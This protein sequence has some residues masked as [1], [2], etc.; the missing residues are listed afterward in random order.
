M[1]PKMGTIDVRIYLL[2]I[3]F[4]IFLEQIYPGEA[5][6]VCFKKF[7]QGKGDCKR[8]LRKRVYASAS[9]CCAG[10]GNG[11]AWKEKKIRKNSYR[12]SSCESRNSLTTPSFQ[13]STLAPWGEWS[14]CTVTCGAGWRSKYRQC[15]TC[16][17][18]DYRNKLFQPCMINSY[19]PVDGNWGPWYPWQPCSKSCGTGIR[20]RT[21]SCIYPPPAHGG[22]D[23]AGKSDDKDTC[24]TKPCPVDG[25]WTLWTPWSSCTESCG[26][27]TMKRTRTCSNPQ[28][29]YRGK[30]C[31]GTGY[32]IKKCENIRCPQDGGWSLWSSWSP[33]PV[34]CGLGFRIRSRMCNSPKPM[35][36]GSSC[37]GPYTEKLDCRGGRPCPVPIHG[38]WSNWSEFGSCKAPRCTAIRGFKYRYRTCTNPKPHHYGQPCHGRS[39][40]RRECY[41]NFECPV[42]G[43]WCQWSSWGPCS[44]RNCRRSDAVEKRTRECSCPKP[45]FKGAPC[46]KEESWETRNCSSNPSCNPIAKKTHT[47]TLSNIEVSL[48]T[49]QTSTVE[50]STIC[51]NCTTVAIPEVTSS[52]KIFNSTVYR[53]L[54]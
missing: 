44:R 42:D 40:D 49:T 12:C 9:D 54:P 20:T 46:P 14:E 22:K 10:K 29:M 26:P 8:P 21:R 28:P 2:F 39:N 1:C 33:C 7:R 50:I 15:P 52:E 45:Q 41:N 18:N 34:T 11:W 47:T 38:G 5:A 43:K 32:A 17:I 3:V 23:C 16:D 36:G 24:N 13:T 25:N 51:T 48:N 27:G 4:T 19:C 31:K 35:Y 30:Q 53:T 37:K 6:V